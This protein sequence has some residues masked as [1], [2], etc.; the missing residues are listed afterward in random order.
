MR[1]LPFFAI[2]FLAS[3]FEQKVEIP[4]PTQFH[5]RMENEKEYEKIKESYENLIH[6]AA[7]GVDWRQV[8][9]QNFAKLI[10]SRAPSGSRTSIESFANGLFQ[11]EWVERGSSNQAGNAKV[12]DYDPVSGTIYAI[13]DGGTLWKGDLASNWQVQNDQ[14]RFGTEVIEEFKVNGS[15]RIIAAKGGVPYYTDDEGISWVQCQG[16]GFYTEEY[17][18]AIDLVRLNDASKTLV[19][20]YLDYDSGLSQYVNKLAVSTDNGVSFSNIK[21]FISDDDE[22]ASMAAEYN[23][24]SA[25]II[26]GDYELYVF[27]GGSLSSLN[28]NPSFSASSEVDIA[29]SGGKIYILDDKTN[30]YASTNGGS[31]LNFVSSLPA[32]AWC[33]EASIGNSNTIYFG[34]VE[35][36]RSTDGG[37]NWT[38]VADWWEYYNDVPNKIHADIMSIRPFLETNGSE[39]TLIPNHGGISKS[40]DYIAT[41]Q[42]IGMQDL[43]IGQ[44]YDV[45]TSPIDHDYIFGGTQDQ[46]YQRTSMGNVNNGAVGFDQVLSGDYGQ[47]QFSNNGQAIWMFYPNGWLTYYNNAINDQ[48]YTSD[49]DVLGNDLPAYGWILPTAPSPNPSDNFIYVGGGNINGGSGSYLIKTEYVNGQIVDSQFNFDFESA[50][51][52]PI[53][54]IEAS[55]IDPNTIY[56]T[57]E[58]GTFFA[59]TDG[60]NTWTSTNFSG[61]GAY[62]IYNM[63]ILVSEQT[64]GLLYVAGSGYSNPGV[65]KSTNGGQS[66]QIADN[67]LPPT[68]IRALAFND[69]E[70]LIF[71]ATD[72]GPYVYVVAQDLWYEITGQGAPIQEFTSVEYLSPEKIIRFGTYGRGIWDLAIADPLKVQNTTETSIK[73]YPTPARDLLTIESNENATVRIFDLNGSSI[74][75]AQN[76]V[77]GRNQISIEQLKPGVYFFEVMNSTGYMKQGRFLKID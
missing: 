63:D 44:F 14:N 47:M 53:S 65:Y 15:S 66:F 1:Y 28:N 48:S 39:L 29:V 46:G 60:G 77:K 2:L 50:S 51:G 3:C 19:F 25:Y 74:E 38:K 54:A 52:S 40:H 20:L 6:K 9:Q 45:T 55:K 4:V 24:S 10:A 35:L 71:A 5:E 49:Y 26:D 13:S 75:F 70:D 41:T 37:I 12:V 17:G 30:L 22:F 32:T 11:G 36:Y 72:A 8:N 42:N 23:G 76:L 16:F 61:P 59:T 7:P 21:S 58:N 73:V 34:E 43:N 31:S 69:T 33:F 68:F 62:W 64:S 57:T 56:V 18:R 67:G 27:N